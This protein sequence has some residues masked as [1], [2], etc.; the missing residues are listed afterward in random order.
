MQSVVGS[1]V[2]AADI[3]AVYVHGSLAS[4]S[5][6]RP[7]SDVDLLAII[8]QPLTELRPAESV[9]AVEVDDAVDLG[10]LLSVRRVPVELPEP[11]VAVEVLVLV[12]EGFL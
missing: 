2:A 3:T 9:R 6:Y 8:E 12:H 11:V 10:P 5:F 1:I 4:G 7:K